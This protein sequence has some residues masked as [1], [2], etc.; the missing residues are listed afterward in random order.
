MSQS[1]RHFIPQNQYPHSTADDFFKQAQFLADNAGESIVCLS[2]CC[3]TMKL[4]SQT[5]KPD[6][7]PLKFR[8]FCNK[9]C[10]VVVK[11]FPGNQ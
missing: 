3:S 2:T 5:P 10:E 6:K 8:T 11:E 7:I 1:L 9:K 4:T